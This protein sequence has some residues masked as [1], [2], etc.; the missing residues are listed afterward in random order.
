MHWAVLGSGDVFGEMPV[1][2]GADFDR[3]ALKSR[4]ARQEKS[5][6]MNGSDL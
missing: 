3:Y 2:D 5:L 1:F 6:P 4:Y